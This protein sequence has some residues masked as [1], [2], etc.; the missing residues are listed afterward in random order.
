MIGDYM[1][2]FI[3]NLEASL[4]RGFINQNDGESGSFKPKLLINNMKKSENVL[5]SLLEELDHCQSF[6]FSVA[7]IKEDTGTVLVSLFSEIGDKRTV[8]LFPLKSHK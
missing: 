6:I 1:G 3:Q 5:T 7:F 4:H 2:N 8:P